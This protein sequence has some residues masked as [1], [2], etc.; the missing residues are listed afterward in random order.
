MRGYNLVDSEIILKHKLVPEHEILSEKEKKKVLKEHN[1]TEEQ[2]PRIRKDDPVAK[3]IGAEKGDLLRIKR[4][5]IT[6]GES[7]YYRIVV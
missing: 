6:A 2:M 1:A 7:T 4:N 3:A 5:S